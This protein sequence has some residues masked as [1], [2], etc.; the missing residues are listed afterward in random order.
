MLDLNTN[1]PAN[2]QKLQ[3]ANYNLKEKQILGLNAKVEAANQLMK[4]LTQFSTALIKT[5]EKG[6]ADFTQDPTMRACIDD[7]YAHSPELFGHEKE[8]SYIWKNESDINAALAAASQVVQ[9]SIG[10]MQ[11]L[12]SRIQMLFEERDLMTKCTKEIIEAGT[13]LLEFISANMRR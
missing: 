7:L 8:H 13:K 9:R 11:H 5:K 4:Q 2:V 10:E 12:A 3:E 6:K 1:V